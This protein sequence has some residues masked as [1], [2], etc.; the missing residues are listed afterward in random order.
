MTKEEPTSAAKVIMSTDP[1]DIK[2]DKCIKR[3]LSE[4]QFLARIIKECV[5]E[6]ANLSYDEIMDSLG[7][8]KFMTVPVEPGL[9]EN[10]VLE[11]SQE[12]YIAGE[13]LIKFDILTFITVPIKLAG[14]TDYVRLYINI[15]AQKN[16][17]PGYDISER[18]IFYMCREVSRQCGTEFTLSKDDPIKYGNI[19]KVYSIWICTES[20]QKRAGTVE[21]INLSKTLTKDGK[22]IANST[23]NDR[24]DIMCLK[25]LRISKNHSYVGVKNELFHFLTDLV[26]D[27]MSKQEKLTA[28]KGYGVKITKTIE[29]EV[30]SMTM[31]TQEIAD[32]NI[33]KGIQQGIEKGQELLVKTIQLLIAGKTEDD[34]RKDGIDNR[35]ISFALKALNKD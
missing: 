24:Y 28:L 4:P 26:N 21:T 18:G 29:S 33:N 8:V 17:M 30:G 14:T 11:L 10:S 34:L 22:I 25:I 27:E 2:L 32:K 15:E 12:D 19:K 1:I 6:C 23:I 35:T 7:Q 13:E 9:T 31:Y 3:I 16:E 5:T 20:A